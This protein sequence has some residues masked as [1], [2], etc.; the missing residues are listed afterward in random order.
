MVGVGG[1]QWVVT[2]VTLL[3]GDADG[4]PTAVV[5]SHS[6]TSFESYTVAALIETRIP[7]WV[8]DQSDCC[9]PHIG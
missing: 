2:A 9:F 3:P 4:Q 1:D 7:R 6:V 5:G 8:V